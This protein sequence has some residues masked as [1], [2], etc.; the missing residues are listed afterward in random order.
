MK[1]KNE[2]LITERLVLKAYDECDKDSMVELLCNDKIKKTFMI[3]DFENMEQAESCFY[4]LMEFSTADNRF[5]YGIYLDGVLIGFLND[6]G[7]NDTKIEVGYVISPAYQGNGY[8]SE[9]LR[10][11]IEELFRM[12]YEH[13]MAGFFEE[14]IASRRVMEKCG[15]HLLELEEDVKYQGIVHRCLYYGIDKK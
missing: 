4:K 2:K 7:I 9:A 3:P 10:A 6:C 11:V 13:I 14:N 8:A 15:M 12:G 5:E 1:K